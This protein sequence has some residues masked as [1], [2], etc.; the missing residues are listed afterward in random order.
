MHQDNFGVLVPLAWG[1]MW[2][3]FWAL[4]IFQGRRERSR[5]YDM[6]EKTVIEGKPLPPEILELLRRRGGPTSDLRAGLILIAVAAGLAL[7]GLINFAQNRVAHPDAEM[8]HGAFGLFPIP[9]LI[10]VAFLIVGYLRNKDLA[11][12]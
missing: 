1:L 2:F 4:I 5:L 8:F 12:R 6:V 10:G 7:S 11:G 3:L 9:G